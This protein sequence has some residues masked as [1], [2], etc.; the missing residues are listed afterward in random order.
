VNFSM[1]LTRLR[2]AEARLNWTL[3]ATLYVASLVLAAFLVVLPAGARAATGDFNGD[4]MSDILWRNNANGH[5]MIW[6]MDGATKIGSGNIAG[7][8]SA[9]S[10]Q[11]V[12]SFSAGPDADIVW[13]NST[14]GQVLVW[15]MNGAAK[16]SSATIGSLGSDWSIQGIGDFDGNGTS[17]ILW[18]SSTTGAVA[19]WFMNGTTKEP[20]SGNPGNPGSAWTVQGIGDFDG[21]GTA[22]ILWRNSSNGHI[23]IWLMDGATKIGSANLV[24]LT[25]QWSIQGVG[26][27]D[28]GGKS[29][30][31]WRNSTTG[32]VQIWIMNGTTKVSS[33]VPGGL[34]TEW[35]I[36]GVGD[37]DVGDKADILWRDSVT[38]HTSIWFM[39]GSAKSTT[40]N[41]GNALLAWQIA[42][43]APYGCPDAVL[44]DILAG[45]NNVRANGSFGPGNPAPSATAGGPLLPFAWSVGAATVARNWAAGCNF[46]HNANRG[47]FGENIYAEGSQSSP[48]ALSGADVVSSWSTEAQNYDYNSNSCAAGEVCGHYTQLV[49]RNTTAVGC[50]VQQCTTNSPFGASFPDW[51]FAVC[52]Y[53][54]PGNFS[55]E[56]PY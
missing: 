42:P 20:G 2:R 27:F 22:D 35:T 21:N 37:F 26:D 39:N 25:P 32:Q 51:A 41:P 33:G 53:S 13:R 19:I 7:P 1:N 12:G 29:D 23:L 43:L 48:V 31:L 55:G 49:W 30:I 24:G 11:G 15:L 18:R 50:A 36:Q 45:S 56:Q 54:P 40:G 14:T 17:D 34:P 16:S 28:G 44:C 46:A 8:G 3:S 5:A 52:D 9:W 10:I 6:L 38:G 47:P 4:G